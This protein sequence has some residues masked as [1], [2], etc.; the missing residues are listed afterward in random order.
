M[1]PDTAQNPRFNGATCHL[2]YNHQ[3]SILKSS[4]S[5]PESYFGLQ[6]FSEFCKQALC[7]ELLYVAGF[8]HLGFYALL[9]DAKTIERLLWDSHKELFQ[10]GCLTRLA[11]FK[12]RACLWLTIFLFLWSNYKIVNY[13][14]VVL[15]GRFTQ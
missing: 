15:K 11:G 8:S 7:N 5:I 1:L 12:Y 13:T 4:N 9:E 3:Q 6:Y 10:I 14:L 2:F